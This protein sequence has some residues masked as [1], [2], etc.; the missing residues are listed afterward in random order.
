MKKLAL[1]FLILIPGLIRSQTMS[2]IKSTVSFIY[3]KDSLGN[4]IPNGTCFFY[5]HQVDYRFHTDL[6]ILNYGKACFEKK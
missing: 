5:G 6:F 3:I 2:E 4:P 1:L